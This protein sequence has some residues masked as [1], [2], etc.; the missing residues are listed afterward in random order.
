MMKPLQRRRRLARDPDQPLRSEISKLRRTASDQPDVMA[1][2]DDVDRLI[3]QGWV[4]RRGPREPRVAKLHP[5]W[6]GK[7][8]PE[9]NN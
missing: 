5:A 8:P 7:L 9:P 2:C 6:R 4:E 1:M 3:A